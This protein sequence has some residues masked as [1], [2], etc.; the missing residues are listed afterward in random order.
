M[1]DSLWGCKES[2][3]TEATEHAARVSP[4][5]LILFGPAKE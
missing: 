3:T 5:N 2:D 1:G 4:C